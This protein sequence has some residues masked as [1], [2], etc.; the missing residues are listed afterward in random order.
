MYC[1]RENNSYHEATELLYTTPIL[2]L[3]VF[4]LQYLRPIPHFNKIRR[5]HL[6]TTFAMDA[7]L[8]HASPELEKWDQACQLLTTM[9]GLQNLEL[10]LS[11]SIPNR[12]AHSSR[13]VFLLLPL[14]QVRHVKNMVVTFTWP[15]GGGEEDFEDLP[16]RVEWCVQSTRSTNELQQTTNIYDST[17]DGEQS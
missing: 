4:D 9:T 14:K 16:F 2:E 7:F 5:L 12:L 3:D 8:S 13:D 10:W 15:P 11:S 17:R 1:S 6:F